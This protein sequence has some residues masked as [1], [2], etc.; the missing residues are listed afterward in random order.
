MKTIL[1][2][3][4]YDILKWIALIFLNAVGICYRAIAAIW[5][6]PYGEEVMGTCAALSVFIGT[7][8]GISAI[9]YNKDLEEE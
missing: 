3:N 5:N 1:P 9:Q 4:V 8:V 2:D 6:L 7:L